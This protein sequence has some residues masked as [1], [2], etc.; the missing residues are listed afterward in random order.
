MT[1]TRTVRL[2]KLGTH[3]ANGPFRG[4][5]YSIYE[6]GTRTPF[7][8]CWKGTIK[9]GVSD[10]IVSTVDLAASLAALTE[11]ELPDDACVD[12]FDVIDA[13]IGAT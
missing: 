4:G 6:G 1:V 11:T 8:T 5:K 10:Q 2:E 12:S 9:P 3:D 13:L 7:I